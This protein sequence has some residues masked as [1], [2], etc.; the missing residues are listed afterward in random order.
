MF[1]YRKFKKEM[2]ER[3]H[4]VHKKGKY[5]TIE[6]NNQYETFFTAEQV[7]DGYEHD[8]RLVAWSHFNTWIFNMKFEIR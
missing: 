6:P 3:G 1:D 8:L 4:E 7:V 2:T 5:I